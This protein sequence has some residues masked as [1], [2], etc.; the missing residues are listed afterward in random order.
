MNKKFLMF[1]GARG[2]T[3]TKSGLKAKEAKKLGGVFGVSVIDMKSRSVTAATS[4]RTIESRT[5]R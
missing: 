5:I 3:R 1:A 4:S 2:D